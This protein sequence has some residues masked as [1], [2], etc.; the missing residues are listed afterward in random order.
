M[1]YVKKLRNRELNLDGKVLNTDKNTRF[2][3]YILLD[4]NN[5]NE[6]VFIDNNYTPLREHKG[7][8][9]YHSTY[10]MYITVLDYR[11]LKKDAE[12]RNKVFF[13]KLGIN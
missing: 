1:K 7:Y 2:Y 13:E 3:C 9:F 12:R 4:L 5:K 11:E 8:I 6:E 10:K